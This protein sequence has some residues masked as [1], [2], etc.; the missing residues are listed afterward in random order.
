MS[1]RFFVPSYQRGYRW[2]PRQV[3]D[4]L[5]DLAEFVDK[6]LAGQVQPDDFYC[7]QPVVVRERTDGKWELID[8]QQRLTT[9][10]LILRVLQANVPRLALEPWTI[11]Y[12]T[13]PR[14]AAFLQAP[15]PDEGRAN[16]DFH[17]MAQAHQTIVAWTDA[18][19]EAE[20]DLARF[21]CDTRRQ[22]ARVIWYEL[23]ES[24]QPIDV[25]VRLN[26]GKIRL[27]SAELI[28]AVLLRR[29]RG[30]TEPTAAQVQL[31]HEWDAL[32]KQLRDP[33]FWGF[34]TAGLSDHATRIEFLF[35]VLVR[36]RN[37]TPDPHDPYGVFLAFNRAFPDAMEPEG[38]S[39]V[40]A[41]MTRVALR[42]QEWHRDRRL[43]HLVGA[44]IHFQTS[45]PRPKR[46]SQ[47][48][49]DLL[50]VRNGLRHSEFD[51]RLRQGLQGDLV[52]AGES[53]AEALETIDYDARVRARRAL[54][55]FNIASLLRKSTSTIRFRFD[56]FHEEQWDLEHI[57][58]VTEYRPDRPETQRRWLTQVSEY[59]EIV[60]PQDN[61]AL[62]KRV[63][64]QSTALDRAAFDALYA[65]VLLVLREQEG[66]TVDNGL[67]NLTLLDAG[68]NRGYRNA[69][70]PVKRHTVLELDKTARF[71]PLC[72]TNVF[73]KYYS[74]GITGVRWSADDARRYLAAM[75][76]MLEHFFG[77]LP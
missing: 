75:V 24:E 5:D 1:E 65:K 38:P 51:A 30:A 16:I 29:S 20:Y 39:V 52:D 45:G 74:P 57:R 67:G 26:V 15:D 3:T 77:E 58:S 68:T 48:V 2:T 46:A 25:F 35:S 14:S 72:T 43:F 56:L 28:R 13:R 4:L 71:V 11:E 61:D 42:V 37:Q 10:Y 31:A 17:H 53:V 70:F 60:P 7:L 55:L 62:V 36:R 18:H 19:P 32:E 54:L 8:G 12:E 44:W 73:L 9:L 22:N 66:D 59:W 23:P 21:L 49:V 47:V 40:W 33:D 6:R 63:A 64:R 41:E 76:E 34:L 27:T 69:P 50:Q